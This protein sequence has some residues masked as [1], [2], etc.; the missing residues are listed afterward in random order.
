MHRVDENKHLDH[1]LRNRRQR[2]S[3]VQFTEITEILKELHCVQKSE[4]GINDYY[5][6]Y[7]PICRLLIGIIFLMI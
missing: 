6:Y 4:H 2:V 3:L 1:Q 5:L 7:C